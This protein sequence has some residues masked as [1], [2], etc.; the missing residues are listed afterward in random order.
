MNR[1]DREQA[2]CKLIQNEVTNWEE[3]EVNVTDKVAF[4]VKNII[5]KARKNYYGIYDVERD[6]VTERKKLWIPLTEWIVEDVVKNIDIDTDDIRVKSRNYSAHGTASVF[7]YVLK[8]FLDQIKFGKLINQVI[9]VMAIDG[10][11]VVKVWRDGK[12][13]RARLIDMLNFIADPSA[14]TLDE[15]PCIERNVL[16]LP[17]FKI[18]AKSGKW[19]NMEKVT[20]TTSIDRIG[21]D[22]SSSSTNSSVIPMVDIYERYGWIPKSILEDNGSDDDYVY[23]LIVAS[24]IKDK[25][26]VCHLIKEVKG[27]PYTIFKYKDIW[28]RLNGRGIGEMLFSLQASIN[29]TV[30]VR[31]NTA[32]IVQSGLWV[33]RGSIT[34]QQVKK[35]FSTS[36][37]KLKGARDE[38]SR[39]DTGTVDPSS[40]RDEQFAMDW[41]TKVTGSFDKGDVTA[42]TPATNA[43]VQERGSQ[44][45]FNLVQE[46]I[47]LALKQMIEEKMVPIIKKVLKPGDV[48]RIT[49]APKDFEIMEEKFIKEAVYSEAQ[50]FIENGGVLLPEEIDA[51]IEN[52]KAEMRSMGEDRYVQINDKAFDMDYDI[53]VQVG[54]EE[55]NSALIAQSITQALQ[56]AAQF[57]GSK[58][59]VD[60][61]LKEIFDTM[62]LDGN[63]L[64]QAQEEL[65]EANARE[66]AMGA[67]AEQAAGVGGQGVNEATMSPTPNSRPV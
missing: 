51:Q 14:N 40:Y 42:S 52:L 45:G 23:A 65:G 13:M 15:T 1:I 43:L 61:A 25:E 19:A 36:V 4:M 62:G 2:A 39:L 9:R 12:E 17:E 31:R 67:E 6:S 48:I 56:V 20:G 54:E 34:P 7:R 58:I 22:E 53:E 37:I 64:I 35:L 63:R 11:A 47:G 24:G 60:E 49:G 3:G 26:P 59:D 27:H 38:F 30:N 5:K 55:L 46:N 50:K 21:F 57:P 66:S 32:R 28:N 10:S 16:T 18:E 8:F 29:E 33:A 41:G 44:V